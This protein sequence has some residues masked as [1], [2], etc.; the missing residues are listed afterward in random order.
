MDH[1]LQ[2][3]ILQQLSLAPLVLLDALLVHL[4]LVHH[5]K[6]VLDTYKILLQLFIHAKLVLAIVMFVLISQHALLVKLDIIYKTLTKLALLALL[7]QLHALMLQQFK[8]VFLATSFSDY[9][10]MMLEQP[11][12]Q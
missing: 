11:L 6:Q 8:H 3:H 9:Q 10:L 4:L 7:M 12:A 5:V 2:T 1:V